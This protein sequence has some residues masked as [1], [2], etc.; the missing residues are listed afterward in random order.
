MQRSKT[1]RAAAETFDQDEL[2]APLAAV[3]IA[4]AGA[5]KKFDETVDVAMRLGR[6]P[7]QGRPD[8]A[9][10]RQPPARH[11]QDRAGPGLRQRGEGRRRP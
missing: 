4:K 11:R 9:R 3:K 6:R 1:Y 5:K 8:G 10:H 7:P 2:Y